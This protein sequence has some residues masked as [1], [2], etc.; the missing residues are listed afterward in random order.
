[1]NEEEEKGQRGEVME[2][3]WVCYISFSVIVLT[4]LLPWRCFFYTYMS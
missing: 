2:G 1:M 3:K 4:Y